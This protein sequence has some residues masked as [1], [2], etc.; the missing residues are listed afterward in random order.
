MRSLVGRIEN[1]GNMVA[2]RSNLKK[3][4][5]DGKK[6]ILLIENNGQTTIECK[7]LINAAGLYASDIANRIEE[8]KNEIV[9]KTFFA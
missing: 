9:L 7:E 4:N 5:Y 2:Y 8:L 6:F 3:I 1:S